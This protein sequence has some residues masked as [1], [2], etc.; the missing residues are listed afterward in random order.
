MVSCLGCPSPPANK[1][2]PA[3]PEKLHSF[4]EELAASGKVGSGVRLLQQAWPCDGG[5]E[6]DCIQCVDQHLHQ[7]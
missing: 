4:L 6:P 2:T 7:L 1:A 3:R 5:G